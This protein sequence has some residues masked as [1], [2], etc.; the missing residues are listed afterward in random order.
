MLSQLAETAEHTLE[1][2][3]ASRPGSARQHLPPPQ[4]NRTRESSAQFPS[5]ERSGAPGT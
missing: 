1:M 5:R 2:N 3:T 4:I